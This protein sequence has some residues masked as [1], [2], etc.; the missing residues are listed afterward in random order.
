MVEDYVKLLFKVYIKHFI[1]GLKD[2][3][4]IELLKK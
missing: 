3:I 4:L 1:E 2:K